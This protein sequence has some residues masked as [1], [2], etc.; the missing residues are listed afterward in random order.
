MIPLPASLFKAFDLIF[1][2]NRPEFDYL[3]VPPGLR[4]SGTVHLVQGE[5]PVPDGTVLVR[6]AARNS[7]LVSPVPIPH[8]EFGRTLRY[9]GP[10]FA[11]KTTTSAPHRLD[12]LAAVGDVCPCCK[13][14]L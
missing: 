13:E 10:G 3:F 8:F 4:V 7:F 9:P 1:D 11:Y 6:D 5:I 2:H 14:T 12:R